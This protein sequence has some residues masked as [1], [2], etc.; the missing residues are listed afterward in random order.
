[1]IKPVTFQG[2]SN[3]KSNLYALELKS[4][5]I[6][7]S[8]ADGYY[9]GYGSE[10]AANIIDNTIQVGSGAFLIQGRMGEIENTEIVNVNIE[11]GKVGY[12]CLRAETYH[13]SDEENCTL[14]VRTGTTLASISLT[15]EDIYQN[16]AE[17]SN[18]VYE[19]P[20]YSFAMS[21]G[22]ITNLTKVIKYIGDY[23]R[24]KEIVDK[25]YKAAEDAVNT[26]N[27]ANTKSNNAVTTANNASAVANTAKNTADT[28]KA[29]ANQASS[30]VTR[31]EGVVDE[32]SK[33]VIENQ[34]TAITKNGKLLSDLNAAENPT[35][36][37]VALF[38][39]NGN[40]KSNTPVDNKDCIR[41]IDLENLL[42]GG[43]FETPLYTSGGVTLTDNNG[44]VIKTHLKI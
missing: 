31:L 42:N 5:F 10:L 18:K 44:N 1:M 11:N 37:N 24:V 27:S 34:G 4:R 17:T 15:Q 32:F 22:N 35:N 30:D 19:L 29:T 9:K 2:V 8:K 20:I 7:Q 41:L 3:F 6:D 12:V 36:N 43:G 25:A 14:V 16:G 39:G 33:R 23:E 13:P 38:N 28:A 40:L 26:A 21:G